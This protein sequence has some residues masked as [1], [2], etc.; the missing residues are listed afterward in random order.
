MTFEVSRT[1]QRVSAPGA[2]RI[3]PSHAG[4]PA[5]TSDIVHGN[6]PP[7][8]FREI[9]AVIAGTLTFVAAVDL[10]LI[11]FGIR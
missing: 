7:A 4:S 5:S 1:R 3:A 8:V 9:A 11:A 10:A 2:V 6:A